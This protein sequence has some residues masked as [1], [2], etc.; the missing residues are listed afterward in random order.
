MSTKVQKRER[1]VARIRAKVTGTQA[2]PRLV[3][4]RSLK[5]IYAQLIDDTSGSTIASASD[6]AT[7][8]KST[9]TQR[10]A[11]VGTTI[12][13]KAQEKGITEVVFDR[14]GNKYHGR[15]KAVADAAR[16]AG[17]KF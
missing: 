9:K 8:E 7:K 11:T 5:H 3:V 2:R 12:S 17:L 4:S 14:N 10:A 13:K 16:E 15:T 1:R 6:V